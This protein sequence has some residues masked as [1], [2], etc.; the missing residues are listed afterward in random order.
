V[1][2][3]A[4]LLLWL[5]SPAI[6]AP[7]PPDVET[8]YLEAR[9]VESAEGNLDKAITIYRQLARELEG[10]ENAELRAR[11]LLALGEA[12][13]SLGQL[14]Q[15]RRAFDTCR[16]ISTS[17]LAPVDTSACAAA[18]RRVALEEGAISTLPLS[19]SFEDA[20]HGFVL[21]SE[22]GSMAVEDTGGDR[23]LVWTEE[24][25]GPRLADLVVAF[26]P[27]TG[28]PEGIRIDVR[29][30]GTVALLEIVV[31][32]TAGRTYT[33]YDQARPMYFFADARSRVWEV[34]IS[35]LQPLDPSWPELD[36]GSIATLRIR[37]STGSRLTEERSRHRIIL[38]DFRV[39]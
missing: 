29:T 12:H 19:W 38:D 17:G 25:D 11:V 2:A 37:D 20:Q 10:K 32:D 30:E 3:A 27:S 16:R 26:A 28:A 4:Y 39:W 31:E 7:G 6:A 18:S 14:Q 33:W 23:C 1:R 13:R 34:A 15:A 21:F 9:L 5:G 22:L 8:R 24:V 35:Q 36:P